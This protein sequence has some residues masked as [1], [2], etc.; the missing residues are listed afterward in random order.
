MIASFFVFFLAGSSL[1]QAKTAQNRHRFYK[2][3]F[4]YSTKFGV[5]ANSYITVQH[6]SRIL[7]YVEPDTNADVFF[8]VAV[9]QDDKWDQ[10]MD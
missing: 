3:N 8:D 10:I 1:C 5:P 9:Y 6:K 4:Y 7:S 2:D